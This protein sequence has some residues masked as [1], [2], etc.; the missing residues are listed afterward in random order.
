V[1]LRER[2]KTRREMEKNVEREDPKFAI[3]YAYTF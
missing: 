3:S 2:W 1:K